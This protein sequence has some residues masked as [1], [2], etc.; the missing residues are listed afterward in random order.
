MHQNDIIHRDIKPQNILFSS[1]NEVKISDFGV[2]QLNSQLRV[3]QITGTDFFLAPESFQKEKTQLVNGKALDIWAL[4]V[5]IYS[6]YH[7]KVPFIEESLEDLVE[8][9][10]GKE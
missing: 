2:S 3:N 6:Y 8:A 4:G 7:M 1:N 5:T 10:T 9:I